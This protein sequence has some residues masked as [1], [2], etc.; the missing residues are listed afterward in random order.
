MNMWEL[1]FNIDNRAAGFTGILISILMVPM[2]LTG[3]SFVR[4]NTFDF[5]ECPKTFRDIRSWIL[6]IGA[7]FFM[8]PLWLPRLIWRLIFRRKLGSCIPESGRLGGF[9]IFW[10]VH[11]SW[12]PVFV[13]LLLHGPN[14]W[15]W[16]MW[17][18][19]LVICDRLVRWERRKVSILLRSAEL[20]KGKV[21]KLTF[22]PPPGFV[23]QAGMYAMLK[24]DNLNGEEWHPFTLTSAPEESFLSMHIRSPDD[25]D[26]CSALRRKLIEEP[27]IRISNGVADKELKKSRMKVIYDSYV[28]DG[29]NGDTE[30]EAL[31][32]PYRLEIYD[33]EGNVKSKFESSLDQRKHE[34]KIALCEGK[35]PGKDPESSPAGKWAAKDEEDDFLVKTEK[36]RL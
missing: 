34:D 20:L 29:V 2:F 18:L 33:D 5:K 8:S 12:K 25:L 14:C 31:S 28:P 30:P 9:L 7:S 23:Y 22:T 24:C 35:E 3:L 15:I 11:R 26:W 36:E 17:P 4:R 10:E 6:L 1:L 21:V 32:R 16:F 27:A 13:L 19:T